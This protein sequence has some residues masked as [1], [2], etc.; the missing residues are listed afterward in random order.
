MRVEIDGTT[1]DEL[2]EAIT[3]AVVAELR[4]LIEASAEPLLVNGDE[5]A[6]LLGISRPHLDRLRAAGVISSIPLGRNRRYDPKVTLGEV[7][8]QAAG[9]ASDV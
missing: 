2:A 9:G 1:P 8:R 3:A 4:P 7:K 6:R 5:M